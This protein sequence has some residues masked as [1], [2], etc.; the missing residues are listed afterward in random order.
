M[1]LVAIGAVTI[2]HWIWTP[3]F[4][5]RTRLSLRQARTD[6]DCLHAEVFPKNGLLFSMTQWRDGA[7]MKRYAASGAHAKVI[8]AARR[9]AYPRHFAHVWQDA[10]PSHD[11][12]F[13]LWQAAT[14]APKRA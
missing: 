10:I 3:E 5:W 1:L 2:R 8:H 7:A 12:A 11:E 9:I 6:G 14:P 13:T 4:V